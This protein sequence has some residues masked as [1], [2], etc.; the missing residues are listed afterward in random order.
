MPSGSGW[1]EIRA[2]YGFL[3]VWRNEVYRTRTSPS[4]RREGGIRAG[5]GAARGQV[6]LA[7]LRRFR[8]PAFQ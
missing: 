6:N 1:N 5:T 3:L 2:A 4:H 7:P 8:D